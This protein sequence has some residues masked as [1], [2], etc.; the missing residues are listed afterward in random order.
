[1]TD[2]TFTENGAERYSRHILLPEVG[3]KGQRKLL[4]SSAYQQRVGAAL[5]RG[6]ARYR[7]DRGRRV[8]A[9]M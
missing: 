6:I 8:R 3:V 2:T 7:N 9:G 4:E 1:M 5:M